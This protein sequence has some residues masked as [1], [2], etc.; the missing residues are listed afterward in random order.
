MNSYDLDQ[1]IA[2]AKDRK[3]TVQNF[4]RYKKTAQKDG[5]TNLLNMSTGFSIGS[6]NSNDPFKQSF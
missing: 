1:Y 2:E 4:A 5:C 6:L 3:P